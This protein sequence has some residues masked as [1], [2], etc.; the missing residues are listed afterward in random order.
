MLWTKTQP[1]ATNGLIIN[2]S[3]SLLTEKT[4]KKIA[5]CGSNK[6]QIMEKIN[7]QYIAFKTVL[8]L[9]KFCK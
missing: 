2:F 3:K 5:K 9:I 4:S 7:Y 6:N 1:K 8:Y